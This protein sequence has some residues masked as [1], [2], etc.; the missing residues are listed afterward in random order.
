MSKY[1]IYIN[2]YYICIC[3]IRKNY[4]LISYFWISYAQIYIYVIMAL[5]NELEKKDVRKQNK[6]IGYD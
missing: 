3:Y 4:S 6:N 2:M 5:S 1:K